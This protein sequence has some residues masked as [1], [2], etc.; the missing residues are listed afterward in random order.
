M[1][2]ISLALKIALR[3]IFSLGSSAIV[4]YASNSMRCE[5][6]MLESNFVLSFHLQMGLYGHLA[7]I[8]TKSRA[9]IASVAFYLEVALS[10]IQP[11]TFV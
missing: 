7:M 11:A 10:Q 9:V 3:A 8:S 2:A 4:F 5:I 6:F 1:N